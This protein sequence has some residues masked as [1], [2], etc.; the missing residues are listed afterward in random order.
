[1][2]YTKKLGKDYGLGF[3]GIELNHCIKLFYILIIHLYKLYYLFNL[4]IENSK[5]LLNPTKE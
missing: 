3:K 4:S 2:L 5:E 1:M